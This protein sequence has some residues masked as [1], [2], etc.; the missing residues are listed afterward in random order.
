MIAQFDYPYQGTSPL[1]PY[2]PPACCQNPQDCADWVEWMSQY[3]AEVMDQAQEHFALLLG[4]PH[5]R[6]IAQDALANQMSQLGLSWRE[7]AQSIRL[8]D[9]LEWYDRQDFPTVLPLLLGEYAHTVSQEY[10]MTLRRGRTVNGYRPKLVVDLSSTIEFRFGLRRYLVL[11][12]CVLAQG[13]LVVECTYGDPPAVAHGQTSPAWPLQIISVLDP[14]KQPER[15]VSNY[16]RRICL[17]ADERKTPFAES[18]L[19]TALPSSYRRR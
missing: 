16:S 19:Y 10:L 12:R 17:C 7:F 14:T 6:I 1:S 4:S 13:P 2:S 5:H 18:P 15:W 11:L 3:L 9:L 8:G